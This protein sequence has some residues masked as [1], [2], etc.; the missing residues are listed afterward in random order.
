[1]TVVYYKATN[2]FKKETEI[3][4]HFFLARYNSTTYLNWLSLSPEFPLLVITVFV[5]TKKTRQIAAAK[6]DASTHLKGKRKSLRNYRARY[7]TTRSKFVKFVARIPMT[8][9]NSFLLDTQ[10]K[11]VKLPQQ[12]K[13]AHLKGKQKSLRNCRA[14]LQ[15]YQT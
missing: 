4:L 2:L 7:S 8:Y 15:H 10:R 1:M 5:R 6:Y 13:A 14:R 3:A 11:L 9:N 12:K